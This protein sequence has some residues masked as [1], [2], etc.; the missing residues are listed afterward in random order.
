MTG[1]AERLATVMA[2]HATEPFPLVVSEGVVAWLTF[3]GADV[4]PDVHEELIG[5]GFVEP[6]VRSRPPATGRA[7]S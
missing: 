2:R 6:T 4:H 1:L 5:L 7:P 3:S